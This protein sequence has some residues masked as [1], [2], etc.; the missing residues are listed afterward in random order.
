MG[1]VIRLANAGDAE[2]WLD[3]LRAV[4]GDEY[5]DRR[6]YDPAWACTQIDTSSGQETWVA[7]DSGKLLCAISLLA[8]TPANKNP[9][10]NLGR[11]FCRPESFADG[12]AEALLLK[13]NELA[14]ERK[15]MVVG[16]VLV[17]DNPQQI[18]YENLGYVC[19]GFQPYK[20]MHRVREGTVFY[21]WFDRPDFVPRL[22]LSESLSQVS[23]L[24][25]L[26]LESL[27]ISNPLCVRD[28]VTGYPLQSDLKMHDATFEDYELWRVHAQ[29][30]NPPVE[31]SGGYNL[32][33]GLL[34]TPIE[35]APRAIL[36][37]REANVV[38]GL[39]YSY[40]E[41]D[42]CVR[43]LDA[44]SIDDLSSGAL[45]SSAVRVAQE[46]LSAVYVEADIL[47]TAPRMLKSAE[48]IG[49]VP[50]AYLPSLFTTA[51][52]HADVVKMV[53][54][55]MVYSQDEMNLTASARKIVDIVGRNLQDQKVGVA[56]I[57]LLRGLPIFDG[58]GDGEL[59]KIA[60][61]FTQKLFRPNERVFGRGDNGD[62]A[63]VVMRGQIDIS[64]DDNAKPLTSIGN[65]QIFG[66]LAFLDGIPRTAHAVASQASILLV[67]QRSEFNQL[68][69]REP[70]LGMVVMR[71]IAMELSNRLRRTNVAVSNAR[72]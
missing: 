3:L 32:G 19:A 54:L 14:A 63:Y 38:A 52:S 53:K 48:Q 22:P 68:I 67:I 71:N 25:M 60:R 35:G 34:R 61:L 64:I 31:I 33:M 5:I 57:N 24:A 59:R 1:A 41:Q 13:I 45:L 15:Q 4:I 58:L 56:V 44:F 46:H 21:L 27:K 39:A 30:A 2:L 55:N 37:Q 50:V 20:H 49:F 70:H 18:L 17:S 16:R 40:D 11:H 72:K 12:S 9:I 62:E 65:G 36:A 23:E 29:S 26:V 8:P 66:E 7:E 6:V 28:G 43:L 47:M 51:G 42:R 69:Q 10:V